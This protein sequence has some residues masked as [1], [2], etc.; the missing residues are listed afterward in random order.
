M[1]ENSSNIDKSLL[2]E[3]KK[4]TMKSLANKEMKNTWKALAEEEKEYELDRYKETS[5]QLEKK[6]LVNRA[7]YL[8]KMNIDDL[9]KI[10]NNVDISL[11]SKE[12]AAIEDHSRFISWNTIIDDI[13]FLVE[14]TREDQ[15]SMDIIKGLELTYLKNL[16]KV[17]ADMK[18]LIY[19]IATIKEHMEDTYQCI[20]PESVIRSC[21]YKDWDKADQQNDSESQK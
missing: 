19:D 4:N 5:I 6:Y 13:R 20:E 7:K 11:N 18:V 16:E 1:D 15:G 8:S 12:R 17:Y 14:S 9:N 21:L 3:E 10:I 2:E